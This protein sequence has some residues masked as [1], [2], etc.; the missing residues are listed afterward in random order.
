MT[1]FLGYLLSLVGCS[2]VGIRRLRAR[3]GRDALERFRAATSPLIACLFAWG[4]CREVA[5]APFWEWNNVRLAPAFAIARGF[6]LYSRPAHGAALSAMYGPVSA[7][8]YLPATLAASPTV[9]LLVAGGLALAYDFLPVLALFLR[10]SG[11]RDPPG[12]GTAAIS[13][14]AF[15]VFGI[16]SLDLPSLNYS[17]G[18]VHADA[19]ALGLAMAACVAT[20]EGWAGASAVLAGLSVLT[21]QTMLPI[22]VVLPVWVLLTTGRRALGRYLLGLALGG[23]L[24]LAATL[25][26]FDARGL[27]FNVLTVPGRYPWKGRFPTNLMHSELGLLREGLFFLVA[28]TAGAVLLFSWADAGDGPSWRR[29]LAENPWCLIGSVGVAMIPISVLGFVKEGGVVNAYSPTTYFLAAAFFLMA[30]QRL[31]PEPRAAPRP[32]VRRLL[33]TLAIVGV[34]AYLIIAVQAVTMNVIG[35]RRIRPWANRPQIAYDYLRRHPGAAYFPSQPLAH[36][37]A[38]GK[39]Y[40][41][42]GALHERRVARIFV[43]EELVRAHLP[44][45]FETLCYS[46]A[47]TEMYGDEL[48]SEFLSEYSVPVEVAELPGFACYRKPEASAAPSSHPGDLLSPLLG[49]SRQK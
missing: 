29:R 8:A 24:L 4:L 5:I 39:L 14:S 37:M 41:F 11:R 6:E 32:E 43:S 27:L 28:L 25:A 42:L 13:L 36:L 21:K 3:G 49:R 38:E 2:A 46:T 34:S 31:R 9:A 30:A 45:G 16:V 7:V 40:H 44:P 19:P 26:W 20:L 47:K 18:R 15:A 23:G 22:V 33:A 10:A 1:L 48:A 12:R 17:A 35:L